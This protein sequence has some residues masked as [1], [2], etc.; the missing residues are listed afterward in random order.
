[1]K[2]HQ[3]LLLCFIQEWANNFDIGLMVRS[4]LLRSS[5]SYVAA[6]TWPVPMRLAS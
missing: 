4:I 6:L 2:I 1:M 5:R 3:P